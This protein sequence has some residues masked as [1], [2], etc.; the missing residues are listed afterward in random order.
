[1]TNNNMREW[2]ARLEAGEQDDELLALAARLEGAGR[3]EPSTIPLDYRRQLRRDL[4][5]HYP[6]AQAAGRHWRLMRTL[7]A[8][9]GL[10][11]IVILTW[12]TMSSLQRPAFGGI[13]AI[14]GSPTPF[15]IPT[16]P[17]MAA[18]LGAYAVDAPDGL[19]AGRTLE[20]LAYWHVPD[21]L[22]A[23]SAFAQ[24]QNDAG[25]VV[26]QSD[27]SLTNM[28]GE[29]YEVNLA[30]PLPAPLP[31]GD[32]TLIFGLSDAAGARLP[33]YDFAQSTVVYEESTSP[34]QVGSVESTGGAAMETAITPALSSSESGYRL[35]GH[36]T[37]GG[38]VTET[39]E[40]D[41]PA[42]QTVTHLLVPGMTMTVTL[43]WSLPPEAPIVSAFVHLLDDAGQTLAQADAPV[44]AATDQVD[45][46][47]TAELALNLPADLPAGEYDL[48]AG[49]YDPATGERLPISTEQEQDQSMRV[50]LWGDYQV[51]GSASL[52]QMPEF[53]I[54]DA[55]HD[56]LHFRVL[57]AEEDTLAVHEVSP[58]AGTAIGGA[59]PTEFVITVDYALKSLPQAILEVR[60][61]EDLGNDSGRGVGLATVDLTRG[62]GT[63]SVV[64]VVNP[65]TELADAADLGVLLQLKPDAASAPIVTVMPD[66]VGWPYRP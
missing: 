63:T 55:Q 20:L 12:F 62:A 59:A 24:L 23:V 22:G 7:A 57:E 9:G 48:V 46:P 18:A 66:N 16:A 31:Y 44:K 25:H 29:A 53:S 38:I 30:I 52:E 45:Q 27:G 8:V 15:Y 43:N 5:A 58:L 41:D 61:V 49:L 11:I 19:E 40:T 32:Y 26:A 37:N 60:I 42:N 34:L 3:N 35:L 64:V 14:G 50:L 56:V 2:S 47:F 17:V 39:V 51:A 1:M 4:L 36:S 65:S 6:A 21:D 13:S 10:A 54:T 28:S 33:L